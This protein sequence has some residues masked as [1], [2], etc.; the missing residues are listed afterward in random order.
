MAESRESLPK[1]VGDTRVKKLTPKTRKKVSARAAR[2]ALR[3]CNTPDPCEEDTS[4]EEMEDDEL[5]VSEMTS[6]PIEMNTGSEASEMAAS[7]NETKEHVTPVPAESP[8]TDSHRTPTMTSRGQRKKKASPKEK[9][10]LE[11][12][13]YYRHQAEVKDTMET[14]AALTK[15][16][17][18]MDALVKKTIDEHPNQVVSCILADV[19]AFMKSSIVSHTA[20]G[21]R[22]FPAL[23]MDVSGHRPQPTKLTQKQA[24]PKTTCPSQIIPRSAA[25]MQ[26][27]GDPPPPKKAPQSPP[28]P[29]GNSGQPAATKTYAETISAP[30][31][32]GLPAKPVH[33]PEKKKPIQASRVFVRLPEDSPLRAAHPL[34]IVKT[35]N[36]VLP[37]DKGVESAA[38]VRTG[39]ALT[40]KT[41]TTP[42]DL[43]L[44]KDKISASLG[45]GTVE[46]DEKWVVVK[47]HDLPTQMIAMN[48]DNNLTSR[49]ISI[50][51]DVF[52]EAAKAFDAMPE[53]GCW[54]QKQEGY[55]TASVRLTFREESMK[56]TPKTVIVMGTR[57]KVEYPTSRGIRPPQCRKC[58][59]LHRLDACKAKPRCRMC[60]DPTHKTAEHPSESPIKCVNCDGPHAADSPS[61]PKT[62][63]IAKRA[64]RNIKVGRT[65]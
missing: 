38:P 17:R 25:A 45:N 7:Q 19:K 61:C 12:F 65:C 32:R 18:E 3:T 43:L 26:P 35:V 33:T 14:N 5:A 50:E 2:D 41:G 46:K 1:R 6:D 30:A 20:R 57:L 44:N 29:K 37:L 59:G 28:P 40:P 56:L 8:N 23:A 64:R 22:P 36:S 63:P 58:W 62:A 31:P 52:P 10:E 39:I 60:G 27:A 11:A 49:E 47:I 4:D 42:E 48:E 34:Y 24:A 21:G 55:L 53:S 9:D 54:I 16:L 51:D 15:F 13:E